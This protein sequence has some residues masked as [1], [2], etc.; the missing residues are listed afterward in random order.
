M[1]RKNCHPLDP[2]MLR[3]F[4]RMHQFH[5][6]SS[7]ERVA[8]RFRVSAEYVRRQ[9]RDITVTD[10]DRVADRLEKLLSE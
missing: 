10:M 2:A 3:L 1:T 8:R 4:A 9:W 6:L 5:L 7:P